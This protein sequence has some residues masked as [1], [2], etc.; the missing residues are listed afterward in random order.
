M[1]DKWKKRWMH[2]QTELWE[3]R[4]LQNI[5]VWLCLFGL[6]QLTASF[7]GDTIACERYGGI[8][9]I[10]LMI[11]FPIYGTN[12]IILPLWRQ[13]KIGLSLL[14]YA[15]NISLFA[16]ASSFIVYGTAAIFCS[17]SNNP[18]SPFDDFEMG[19]FIN[20]VSTL[21]MTTLIGLAIRI[22][23][24]SILQNNKNKIAELKLLKAQVN[25]HFLFN[26]LNNLYGLA[27]VKSD[28]LPGL[29]LQLS[30]LLRYSLYDTQVRWVPLAKEVSYI[31]NYITLEKLRLEDRSQIHFSIEGATEHL[32]IAPMLLI[33]FLEN[34]FKHFSAV[35]NQQAQ[36]DI[37]LKVVDKELHFSCFNT[38]DH[39][40]SEGPRSQNASGIG[41]NNVRKR[42]ELLYP[43]KHQLGIQQEA[44]SFRVFLE[45][46][47]DELT[48][49]DPLPDSR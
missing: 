18:V 28:K 19:D 43:Y 38:I 44:T 33:V 30:D 1:I 36:I 45:L 3:N 24:D 17:L 35:E 16:L 32:R 6:I 42:L 21:I 40:I 15:L 10:C 41:L 9:G 34:A 39:T 26:T 31:E 22:A 27:V 14:L 23:R 25:P 37:Q 29:M 48:Y 47:L 2:F 49:E 8:L 11:G 4:L 12:M 46:Q 13:K 7:E 20:S 5:I